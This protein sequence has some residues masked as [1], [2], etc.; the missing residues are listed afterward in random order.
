MDQL[1]RLLEDRR[2]LAGV[3]AEWR[4][5]LDDGPRLVARWRRR[6]E[7][8]ARSVPTSGRQRR[9]IV[10]VDDDVAVTVDDE[11]GE[12]AVISKEDRVVYELDV[13]LL[14][15]DM[16]AALQLDG[17]PEQIE[18]GLHR[19]GTHL[20]VGGL[21]IPIFF[22]FAE[23]P[24]V[25]LARASRCAARENGPFVLMTPTMR[26]WSEPLRAL[27]RSRAC[28]LIAVSQVL[29]IAGGTFAA[30]ANL[31]RLA[32]PSTEPARK[33]AASGPRFPTP[34][35]SAWHDVRLRFLDGETVT[36]TVGATTRRYSFIEMGLAHARSKKPTVLWKLLHNL[37][38][39][40]GAFTW[41]SHGASRRVPKNIERLSKHLRAF[42]SMSGDPIPHDASTGG[43]RAA[44]MIEP[45]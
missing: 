15:T 19:L 36:V 40:N 42:F 17:Q 39:A 23:S 45:D 28:V 6:R 44:F 35:R 38:R 14:T 8:L 21:A 29:T 22:G 5:W 3:D 4:S 27:L 34:P 37:A 32:S 41:T 12:T 18:R 31:D 7:Q 11:S 30:V 25:L 20:G 2:T 1:W 24:E 9:R 16:A 26:F 43:Y 33:S 10:D 13:G